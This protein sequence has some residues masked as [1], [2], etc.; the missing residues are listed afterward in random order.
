MGC[1]L[2]TPRGLRITSGSYTGDGNATQAITGLPFTPLYVWIHQKTPNYPAGLRANADT[3]AFGFDVG[4]LT[5][6]YGDYIHSLDTAG[7]T[8]TNTAIAAA[9]NL[10]KA[11]QTYTYI[12]L[13]GVP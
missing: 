13:G 5:S 9:D 8:V 12:A 1:R 4:A 11:A 2:S 3:N 7:F 6:V 10:N